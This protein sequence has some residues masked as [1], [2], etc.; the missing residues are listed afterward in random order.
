MIKLTRIRW[1][2]NKASNRPFYVNPDHIL[3]MERHFASITSGEEYTDIALVGYNFK[4]VETP[5][6]ISTMIGGQL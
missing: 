4:V 2:D 6:Q 5:K 1:Q 3:W